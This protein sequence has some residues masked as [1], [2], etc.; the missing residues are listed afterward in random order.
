[1]FGLS[2]KSAVSGMS[3]LQY[4][5]RIMQ[6]QQGCIWSTRRRLCSVKVSENLICSRKTGCVVGEESLQYQ[7]C[8]ICNTLR[9]KCVQYQEKF[10]QSEENV[11]QCEEKVYSIRR[12]HFQE[13]DSLCG[14]KRKSAVIGMSRLKYP[15]KKYALL[16]GL[17]LQYEGKVMQYS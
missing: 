9:V 17:H 15:E 5:E 1:M 4:D 2:I 11:V 14:W 6:Q 12:V 3:H 16:G 13:E 7:E 8:N 10:V